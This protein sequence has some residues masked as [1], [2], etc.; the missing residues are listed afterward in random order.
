MNNTTRSLAMALVLVAVALPGCAPT[1]ALNKGQSMMLEPARDAEKR[2]DYAKALSEYRRAA[3]GG[4]PYAQYRLARLYDKGLG[5]AASA[6]EAARWYQAAADGN[7]PDAQIALARMYEQGRGVARDEAAALALYLK[8]AEYERSAAYRLERP[9]MAAVAH[10]RAGQ[11]IENGRG[12]EADPLTAVEY[13]EYAAGL[14]NPDGDFQLAELYRKGQGVAAD[15]RA[16]EDHYLAAAV[17]YAG[18]TWRDDA[19]AQLR[20]GTMYLEGLGVAKDLRRGIALLERSAANGHGSAQY[21]LGQLFEH[22]EGFVA[23]DPARALGYY[24]QAAER[25]H[26]SAIRALA[27]FE[28]NGKSQAKGVVPPAEGEQVAEIDEQGA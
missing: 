20:L 27:A 11:M 1:V 12:T 5:T 19:S 9:R 18:P 21:R 14:D 28:E 10:V 22:G 16:A 4:I 25:G 23:A 7:Y 13:Y 2:G 17:S 15:A 8:A 24:Q 26:G 6:E 3:Q